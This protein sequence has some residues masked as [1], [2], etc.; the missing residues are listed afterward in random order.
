MTTPLPRPALAHDKRY[1]A[2]LA[3]GLELLQCFGIGEHWL[4]HQEI[5]RRTRLPK[6][7]VS[8]LAFTLVSLGFLQHD[9][10]RGAYALGI[11]GLTLGF[12]VLS[13]TEVAHLT[14]P[15]LDELAQQSQAAVSLGCR[16]QLSMVYIAHSR[17]QGRLTLGLDV[18]ARLPIESTSM[19]RALICALHRTEREALFAALEQQLGRAW[20]ARRSALEKAQAQYA[21]RGF[22]TSVGE[23]EGDI[24]AVGT[25]IDLGDGREPY[26][27]N[28]G[29]PIGQLT[30]QRLDEELGPLLVAAA[31]RI[32]AAIQTEP[33]AAAC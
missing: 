11:G 26:A 6:A 18:G 31:R 1:V 29:G 8:R 13:N 2:A 20:P 5:T 12:R 14:R 3:R 4:S 15:L 22:V 17:G 33:R 7:T 30:P 28:I 27:I 23:W 32:R 19:G 21:Q 24:S 9:A 10:R 25:A 16:H